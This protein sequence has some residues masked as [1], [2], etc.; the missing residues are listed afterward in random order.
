[1]LH[2]ACKHKA[3]VLSYAMTCESGVW[4]LHYLPLQLQLLLLCIH[5]LELGIRSLISQCIVLLLQCPHLWAHKDTWV[6]MFQKSC[7]L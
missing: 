5:K 6:C 1:M 4:Y 7:K 3:D 2:A